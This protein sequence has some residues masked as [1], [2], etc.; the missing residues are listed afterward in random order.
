LAVS[1]A[2]PAP[3]KKPPPRASKLDAFKPVIDEI[4]RVDL[5]APR[6]QRHAVT[7]IYARLIDEQAMVAVSYQVLRAYVAAR[8]PE[9]RIEARARPGAGVHTAVSPAWGGGPSRSDVWA[10]ASRAVTPGMAA[11]ASTRAIQAAAS[12]RSTGSLHGQPVDR[13]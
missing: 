1:S 4:L 11:T 8:R 2:W 12:S 7:R 9:I 13:V 6:K 3:R 5:D 10:A